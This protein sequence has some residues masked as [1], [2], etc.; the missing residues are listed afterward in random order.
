MSSA[1]PWG[2]VAPPQK[3]PGVVAGLL[4]LV[5]LAILIGLGV[6]QLQRLKWKEG[7][8]AHMA[9]LQA[10]PARPLGDVLARGG[11]LD[12]TR[13][14]FDCPDLLS[15]PRAR[16]YGVQDGQIV[17]RQMVACPLPGGRPGSVMVDIGY[18]DCAPGKPI[19]PP[20]GPLVGILRKPDARTFVTPPDQPA[21]RLWYWRDLPS[22]AQALKAGTPLPVFLALERGPQPATGCRLARAPIPGNIPNRHC[23]YALTWFGL[24]AA[25]IGVYAAMLLRRRRN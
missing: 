2:E 15:A 9:A 25:L 11:D 16:V 24:A 12:F 18:E 14:S 5:C 6:W 10:A 4:V 19:A 22:M 21:T 20:V 1:K 7:V 23:E 8:L 3:G 13:A 17:Y